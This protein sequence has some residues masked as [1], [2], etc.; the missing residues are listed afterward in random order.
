MKYSVIVA[1]G[2]SPGSVLAARLA[3]DSG[4]SILL[5]EA[6]QNYADPQMRG[7]AVRDGG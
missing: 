1:G 5:L 4:R 7:E 2:E 3:E 6:G